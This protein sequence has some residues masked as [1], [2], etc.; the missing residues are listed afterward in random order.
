MVVEAE[1][2]RSRRRLTEQQV[3]DTI[4]IHPSLVESLGAVT[5]TAK[6]GHHE[7]CCG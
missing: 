5:T 6:T 3:G 2:P 1:S 7:G 4:L